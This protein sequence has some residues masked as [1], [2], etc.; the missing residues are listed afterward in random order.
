MPPH[1]NEDFIYKPD[2]SY[3]EL[4]HRETKRHFLLT[5]QGKMWKAK[6]EFVINFEHAKVTR[7]IK[8]WEYVASGKRGNKYKIFKIINDI[9]MKNYFLHPKDYCFENNIKNQHILKTR[10]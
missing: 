7:A 2:V 3:Q 1:K 6:Q 9:S 8:Y 4:Q 10:N 5:K